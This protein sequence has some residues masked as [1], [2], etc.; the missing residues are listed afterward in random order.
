[1]AEKIRHKQKENTKRKREKYTMKKI[2]FFKLTL[3]SIFP[4][5][6]CKLLLLWSQFF[7]FLAK[8]MRKII[9]KSFSSEFQ[10]KITSFA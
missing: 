6:R 2:S 5:K 3:L 1:M 9:P 7:W 8:F 10:F 4:F